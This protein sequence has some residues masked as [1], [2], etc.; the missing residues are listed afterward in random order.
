MLSV[1]I[2]LR[3]AGHGTSTVREFT[4]SIGLRLVEGVSSA[5]S[6]WFPA[7]RYSGKIASILSIAYTKLSI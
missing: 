6:G 2:K 1:S 3:N 5:I 7:S 4:S